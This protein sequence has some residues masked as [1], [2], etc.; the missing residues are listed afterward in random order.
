MKSFFATII[1]LI[2]GNIFLVSCHN[3]KASNKRGEIEFK[4]KWIFLDYQVDYL[5]FKETPLTLKP[6]GIDFYFS[7]TNNSDSAITLDLNSK[8][9]INRFFIKSNEEKLIGLKSLQENIVVLSN[10]SIIFPISLPYQEFGILRNVFKYNNVKEISSDLTKLSFYFKGESFTNFDLVTIPP[11]NIYIYFMF[12]DTSITCSS[13][14]ICSEY[15]DPVLM[16]KGCLFNEQ[17]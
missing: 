8:K 10:D 4:I 11:N 5:Y 9:S 17:L 1:I 3:E 6:Y 13:K 12:N 14:G 15:I 2:I 16:W 7:A